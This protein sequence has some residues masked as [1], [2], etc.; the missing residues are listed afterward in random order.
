M[1]ALVTI[2]EKNLSDIEAKLSKA[3]N[4]VQGYVQP[5]KD[6]KSKA[7][8]AEKEFKKS[9]ENDRQEGLNKNLPPVESRKTKSAKSAFE[10]IELAVVKLETEYQAAVAIEADFTEQRSAIAAEIE[11]LKSV[12]FMKRILKQLAV[13]T[14]EEA[15]AEIEKLQGVA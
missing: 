1:S 4:A 5:L 10:K 2:Q 14:E 6:L 11:S 15:I 8:D 12:S 9:V 13:S 7:Y 3:T